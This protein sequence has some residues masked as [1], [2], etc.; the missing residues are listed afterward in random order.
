MFPKSNALDLGSLPG[1]DDIIRHGLD[2]GIVVLVR[3]NNASPSV[4]VNGLY[5][6]GSIYVPREKAGLANFVSLMLMRGTKTRDFDTLHE[7]IEKHVSR[8]EFVRGP[9]LDA[10]SAERCAAQPGLSRRSR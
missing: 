10:D 7:E 2:N 8:Q 1:P 9:G 5:R 6:S 3:E 4:V